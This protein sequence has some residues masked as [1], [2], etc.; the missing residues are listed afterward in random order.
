MA[1]DDLPPSYNDEPVKAS[2]NVEVTGQPLAEAP[3]DG[4]HEMSVEAQRLRAEAPGSE[5]PRYELPG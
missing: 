3:S 4:A 1:M 2:M 5:A